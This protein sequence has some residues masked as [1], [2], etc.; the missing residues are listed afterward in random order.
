VAFVSL[1]AITDASLLPDVVV[2]SLRLT[3]TGPPAEQV[4][5]YLRRRSMLLVLDNCGSPDVS[6]ITVKFAIM[7]A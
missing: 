6:G 4:L 1:A 2:R 7:G 5:A 3:L